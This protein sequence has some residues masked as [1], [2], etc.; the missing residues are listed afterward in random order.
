LLTSG[1]ANTSLGAL[2]LIAATT[3]S[4]NVAIGNQCLEGLTTG[5]E[6]VIVS[7]GGARY[8][9]TASSNTGLGWGVYTDGTANLGPISGKFN[10]ALGVN[11]GSALRGAESNNIYLNTNGVA[12]ES[13]VLRIGATT[14]S[15][16]QQL[17]A[18]YIAGIRGVTTGQNNAIAVLIDSNGQLG[19]VSSS[20]RVKENIKDMGSA[21]EDILKLRPVTFNYKNRFSPSVSYGLIAEE[22][23]DICPDLVV[24]DVEGRPQTDKISRSTS[25]D[26][27]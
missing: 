9:T 6:N 24:Y 5:D 20:A 1:T 14:G 25:L 7:P 8:M 15:G 10:I 4:E 26:A 2:N 3:A 18:S 21:S 16:D 19:T 22:V 27:Q 17:A 12:T 13:N 11:T 23:H